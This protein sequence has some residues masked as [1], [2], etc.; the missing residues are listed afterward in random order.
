MVPNLSTAL[1]PQGLAKD[2]AAL[3]VSR[4]SLLVGTQDKDGPAPLYEDELFWSAL[5][6]K[7]PPANLLHAA[8]ASA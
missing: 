8:V 4:K 2:P 5:V 6:R 3:H 7:A 1:G